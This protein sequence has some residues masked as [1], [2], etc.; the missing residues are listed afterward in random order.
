ME[1]CSIRE[2]LSTISVNAYIFDINPLSNEE[3]IEINCKVFF[4][5]GPSR[6]FTGLSQ[7]H[8]LLAYGFKKEVHFSP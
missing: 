8:M 6:R 4:T 7:Y 1:E 3:N 5:V 2:L